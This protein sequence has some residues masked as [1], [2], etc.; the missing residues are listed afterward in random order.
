MLAKV[1]Y[2]SKSLHSNIQIVAMSATLPNSELLT[3]W[4]QAEYYQTDFRPIELKEMIKVG[5]KIYDNSMATIREISTEEYS[6]LE[7]DHDNICQLCIETIVSGASVIVFCPSKDWCEKLALHVASSIYKLGKSQMP[8][9]EL[10]RK[11]IDMQ[12]TVDVK[13]HLKNTPPG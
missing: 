5:N 13:S 8:I 6:L 4:L 2:C 3:N 10:I 9:G 1:L 11:Q 12:R 7:N